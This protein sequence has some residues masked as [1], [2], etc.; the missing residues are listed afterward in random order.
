MDNVEAA[1]RTMPGKTRKRWNINPKKRWVAVALL[2]ALLLVGGAVFYM[3]IAGMAPKDLLNEWKGEPAEQTL[4]LEEFLVNL[5]TYGVPTAPVLRIHIA[6]KYLDE[7]NQERMKGEI[8]M[9]RDLILTNLRALRLETVL[10]EA[11]MEE[12][13]KK[14]RE[15]L[16][17]Y[18]EENLV[19]QIYIT[20]LIVR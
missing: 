13:K 4:V 20:D 6:I 8:P 5:N 19:T 15:D 10:E 11:S 2:I 17:A 7:K 1:G 12:F 14:T 3:K 9:I 18:F 16:N